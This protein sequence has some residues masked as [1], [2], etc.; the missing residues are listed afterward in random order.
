MKRN[1]ITYHV[2]ALDAG[3]TAME[4]LRKKGFSRRFLINLKKIPNSLFINSLP[5][6]Q[7]YRLTAG[8]T[9]TVSLEDAVP[10]VHIQ[11]VSVPFQIV[12]EDLD[13]LVLSKP[14]GVPVHPSHDHQLD[15]VANGIIK[16][17]AQQGQ[18]MAFRSVN[19]LDRDTTGLLLLA[20]HGLAGALLS[21][22]L[23]K[24]QVS[25]TYLAICKGLLP[26]YGVI[27]APIR[28]ET[29]SL[30]ARCVDFER[31]EKAVTHY[32]RLLYRNGYSLAKV[33]LETGKTHQIRVHMSYIG[34][35]L[36][37]DFLYCP[38]YSA[39]NRQALHSFQIGFPHPITGEKM[40]FTAPLPDDMLSLLR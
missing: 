22:S 28:R 31:G 1:K 5:V 3:Q 25:R 12:W 6:F 30:I 11:P 4:F 15:T 20:K 37:G 21:D 40:R 13:I 39:I 2:S 38:D 34:H 19:R 23:I 29:E 36:P 9:I 14:A 27:D 17:F 32:Q 7:I 35:P 10:S 26:A 24:R 8:D 33:T 16:Y 18:S